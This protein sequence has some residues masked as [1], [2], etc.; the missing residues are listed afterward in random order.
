MKRTV[1]W[2]IILVVVF[3]FLRYTVE[4]VENPPDVVNISEN[5]YSFSYIRPVTY[6]YKYKFDPIIN[7]TTAQTTFNVPM[8]DITSNKVYLHVAIIVPGTITDAQIN[9]LKSRIEATPYK[10]SIKATTIIKTPED[11]SK[12]VYNMNITDA[13]IIMNVYDL[14]E[15]AYAQKG[16]S[17]VVLSVLQYKEIP[18]MQPSGEKYIQRAINIPFIDR[19][20]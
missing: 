19:T 14:L 9:T 12:F 2:L 16:T 1:V 3:L 4:G 17:P 11:F 7:A 6:N 20:I 10:N 5:P 18:R 8:E 13:N 15:I